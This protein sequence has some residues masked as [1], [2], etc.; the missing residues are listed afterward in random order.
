MHGH[1]K[2]KG[3][4]ILANV[5]LVCWSFGECVYM[6][7]SAGAADTRK[8]EWIVNKSILT[9][10]HCS[11][12]DGEGQPAPLSTGLWVVRLTT[13]KSFHPV[14]SLLRKDFQLFGEI[15]ILCDAIPM[16]VRYKQLFVMVWVVVF[17]WLLRVFS[18]ADVSSAW[19]FCSW[20][21]H[22]FDIYDSQCP[23]CICTST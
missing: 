8:V 20:H 4:E 11:A 12:P 21:W 16:H 1:H 3:A 7:T 13:D 15:M 2:K 19:A 22:S 14:S 18:L 6:Q 9:L 17:P 23:V 5:C 10:T